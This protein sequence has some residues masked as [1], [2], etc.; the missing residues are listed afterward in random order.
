MTGGINPSYRHSIFQIEAQQSH[1][2]R[3][4]GLSPDQ[5]RE[6]AGGWS[7]WIKR[8]RAICENFSA[9]RQHLEASLPALEDLSLSLASAFCRPGA[10]ILHF[11]F[12]ICALKTLSLISGV[13]F[14]AADRNLLREHAIPAPSFALARPRIVDKPRFPV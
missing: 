6:L 10:H 13:S 12:M 4:L 5:K 7:Q 1:I 9:A 11:Q 14:V 8:R 2:F 3:S